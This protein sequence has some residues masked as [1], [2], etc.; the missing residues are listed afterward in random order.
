MKLYKQYCIQQCPKKSK[1]Q[2]SKNLLELKLTGKCLKCLFQQCT[3]IIFKQIDL[4]T[5][6]MGQKGTSRVTKLCDFRY[7]CYLQKSLDTS[8][9]QYIQ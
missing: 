2:N 6:T 8:L 3:S 7:G 5:P 9:I 1:K 4:L